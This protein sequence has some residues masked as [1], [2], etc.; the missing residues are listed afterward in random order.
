MS[1]RPAGEA[2]GLEFRCAYFARDYEATLAFYRDGLGLPILDGWDRGRD[3]RGTIFGA[4][5][6]A[7]EVMAL[8]LVQRPDAVWDY[9][10]PQGMLIVVE[11][12]EVEALHRRSS[13]RGLAIREPLKDQS[14]GHRSFVVSDPDGVGIYFFS[15]T[16]G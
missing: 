2:S 7:I 3:D 10:E 5:A 14:W 16:T 15:P 8:P 11:V 6:G 12:E 9:R 4:G 13:E 1:P